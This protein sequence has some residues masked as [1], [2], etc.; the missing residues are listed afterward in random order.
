MQTFQNKY[1]I[2]GQPWIS[3][4]KKETITSNNWKTGKLV[5]FF[6]PYRILLSKLTSKIWSL[7]L[8]QNNHPFLWQL[9]LLWL[10][11]AL[12]DLRLKFSWC[13]FQR[14]I[15][16]RCQRL[17]LGPYVCKACVLTQVPLIPNW[18][19]WA[20][21]AFWYLSRS[22]CLFCILAQQ[23]LITGTEACQ[24]ELKG[25]DCSSLV[26]HLPSF[27]LLSNHHIPSSV[28]MGRLTNLP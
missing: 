28:V 19:L 23:S 21:A 12:L 20:A 9:S 11:A 26:Y 24:A 3:L 25:S 22:L 15:Y 5:G 27:Y 1:Q 14:Y 13:S 16:Y 10:A 7:R 2:K 17:N 8:T 4:Q 18:L 6:L